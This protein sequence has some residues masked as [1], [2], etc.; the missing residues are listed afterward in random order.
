MGRTES[1]S[2]FVIAGR[3]QDRGKA[4]S[5]RQWPI[6]AI[7]ICRKEEPSSETKLQSKA[8]L[9]RGRIRRA[10]AELML[11]W[12]MRPY[13]AALLLNGPLI[14]DRAV[15]DVMGYLRLS[16][17]SVPAHTERATHMFPFRR[18]GSHRG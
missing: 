18:R 10:F 7:G 9:C 3:D 5:S 15:P 2:S 17:L 16:G 14:F 1:D 11:S 13:R 8:R 12:E 4:R 6:A